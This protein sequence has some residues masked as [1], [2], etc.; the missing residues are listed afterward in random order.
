M[1]VRR[2]RR[3]GRGRK[4]RGRKQYLRGDGE[5][6]GG[7]GCRRTER[8]G[9]GALAGLYPPPSKPLSL[10]P[11]FFFSKCVFVKVVFLRR[12]AGEV[13]ASR[14]R[15][16]EE[17]NKLK[18]P[19]KRRRRPFLFP[20]PLFFFSS[21]HSLFSNVHTQTHAVGRRRR[22][23]VAP[24]SPTLSCVLL[25]VYVG[26]GLGRRVFGLGRALPLRRT[27]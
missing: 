27:K 7:R 3:W 2:G 24:T 1:C 8:A 5:R 16:T 12:G 9:G 18:L 19:K 22:G 17:R 6:C 15:V 25:F 4:N 13:S 26:Q 21:F 20:I 11:F 23:V 14:R 10:L